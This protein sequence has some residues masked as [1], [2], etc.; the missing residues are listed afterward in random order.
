MMTE[1]AA[2]RWILQTDV[3][4]TPLE[5]EVVILDGAGNMYS[6]SGTAQTAWLALPGSVAE[7]VQ[8]ITSVFEIDAWQA[9]QDVTRF[10]TDLQAK[11]LVEPEQR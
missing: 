1:H 11:Q 5:D 9:E 8:A 6:L 7:L 3:L 4:T 2:V 10:L